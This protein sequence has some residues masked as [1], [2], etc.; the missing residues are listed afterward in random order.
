MIAEETFGEFQA[1]TRG[2]R[3]RSEGEIRD[4]LRRMCDTVW[5]NRT[6]VPFWHIPANFE[7]DVDVILY[8][9]F[10]EL[11]RYRATFGLLPDTNADTNPT[12][13]DQTG[14]DK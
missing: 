5:G 4:A 3:W 2:S 13:R 11:K 1:M 12:R 8:D 14:P 10:A 7:T 6:R 9:V